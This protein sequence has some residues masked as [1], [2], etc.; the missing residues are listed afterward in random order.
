MEGGQLNHMSCHRVLSSFG[1]RSLL[2]YLLGSRLLRLSQFLARAIQLPSK[3]ARLLRKFQLLGLQLLPMLL[4]HQQ[5]G[6]RQIGSFI[7]NSLHI[8]GRLQYIMGVIK[9]FYN[10]DSLAK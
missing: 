9:Q 5:I 4:L 10:M 8:S 3:L 1:A 6:G 2:R 7:H